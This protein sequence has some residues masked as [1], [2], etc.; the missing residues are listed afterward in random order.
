[1]SKLVVLT[2]GGDAPGMNAAIRATV[3][4]AIHHGLEVYGSE[5][6][7]QGL[8]K[9]QLFPMTTRSVANCIQRG[10]TILKT[11]RCEAFKEKTTR[12]Q[13]R[14][15]LKEQNIEYLIV[16]GG[17]GSFR[18]AKLLCDEGGPACVGIPGTIDNDIMGSE[19]TI[20]FDTA[21]N[22]ALEAI[23]KIRDT[24]F[25]HERNFLI[26]VMGRNAGFLA[27]DVGTAGGAEIILTP[28]YMMSAEEIATWLDKRRTNKLASIIVVAE[29][30]RAGWSIELSK[31]LKQLADADYRVCILGHV[32]RGGSPTALDRCMGSL[33]GAKA[34]EALLKG[35]TNKMMAYNENQV[36][37]V[38]FPDPDNAT[39]YLTANDLELLRLN[40]IL[41][42]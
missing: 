27:L 16:I 9:N 5:M 4:T 35:A 29:A 30:N 40:R 34:V 11:A 38:D 21:R 8:V 42:E 28:E 39:R 14:S 23:D 24:A 3:R 13:V 19:Y 18:G 32:Q 25:S 10:G 22:T 37:L 12:D 2:S 1:M 20:G 36:E 15:F 6:G 7:Y 41:S 31:E 26:E 17:D 33:M